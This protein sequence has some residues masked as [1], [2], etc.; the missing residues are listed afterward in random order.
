MCIALSYRCYSPDQFFRRNLFK[1]FSIGKTKEV[2]KFRK[3]K[4]IMTL[5]DLAEKRRRVL[6]I[7]VKSHLKKQL[8]D[9]KGDYNY[10]CDIIKNKIKNIKERLNICGYF[11]FLLKPRLSKDMTDEQMADLA[12]WSEKIQSIKNR[13]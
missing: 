13:M 4:M 1:A 12:S 2:E 11:K 6:S 3:L 8:M 5:I 10:D 9:F 7:K